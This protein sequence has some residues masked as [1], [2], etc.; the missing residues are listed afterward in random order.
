MTFLDPGHGRI[1]GFRHLRALEGLAPSSWSLSDPP[2]LNLLL[3]WKARIY[4]PG[5]ADQFHP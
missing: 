3:R 5:Y 4:L 2:E 1:E